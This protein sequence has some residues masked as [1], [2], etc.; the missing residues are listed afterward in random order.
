M[1]L[2]VGWIKT[3]EKKMKNMVKIAS[4]TNDKLN[5]GKSVVINMLATVKKMLIIS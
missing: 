1:L 4:I 3:S 5:L 2:T